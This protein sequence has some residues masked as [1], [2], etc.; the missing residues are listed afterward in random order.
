LTKELIQ[1][2][3]DFNQVL[4]QDFL[5]MRTIGLLD[6]CN[7]GLASTI[8]VRIQNSNFCVEKAYGCSKPGLTQ[9]FS[10]NKK[11]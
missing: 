2:A 10:Q 9:L 7:C 6:L 5:K 4:Y 1:S 8:P 11:K 3:S